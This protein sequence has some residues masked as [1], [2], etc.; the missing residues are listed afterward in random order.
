M[1]DT[2]RF[3]KI[4]DAEQQAKGVVSLAIRPNMPSQYGQGGLTGKQLQERFDRL[5]RYI[6]EKYNILVDGLASHD[7]LDYFKLPEGY[8]LDTLHD[9]IEKISDSHGD[10]IVRSPYINGEEKLS[11]IL[12]KLR[13][14][15]DEIEVSG[16]GGGILD[17]DQLP[18]ENIMFTVFYRTPEGVYWYDNG[19]HKVAN[20]IDLENLEGRIDTVE[21]IAKG[22][23]QAR[24]YGDY[25]TMIEALNALPN[26][27]YNV[28]Q[29]IMI[30][31]LNVP[32]LWVSAI[33]E[34]HVEY[35]YVDDTTLANEIFT[36]GSVQVGYYVLSALETQKVDLTDYVKNTDYAGSIADNAYGVMAIT[37]AS[38]C[39]LNW[40]YS[41]N[42]K[43]L[44]IQ[45]PD[46]VAV[47]RRNGTYP[48]VIGDLDTY[49]KTGITGLKQKQI[50]G[51]WTDSYGN[52]IALTDEEKASALAWLGA[53]GETDYATSEKAG[54]MYFKGT[55]AKILGDG[56]LYINYVT[57][58]DFKSGSGNNFLRVSNAKLVAK[59]GITK[60]SADSNLALTD[61]E[62]ASAQDWLGIS[63]SSKLYKH[64]V[65]VHYEQD[66]GFFDGTL[67]KY[68]RDSAP[69]TSI[70]KNELLYEVNVI[71]LADYDE[72]YYGLAGRFD[73]G[74]ANTVVF[75][76]FNETRQT[77]EQVLLDVRFFT[78]TDTV[79][80][81]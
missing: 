79:T 46:S 65:N 14:E 53:V 13:R 48:L 70:T 30:V 80:E 34:E 55:G 49:I 44:K 11:T 58:N 59:Y 15:I 51:V 5:A 69:I 42:K 35:A 17:V 20:E 67:I 21:S 31:T 73:N 45:S 23:G 56:E 81:V 75:L 8:S 12:N 78:I 50:D 66:N 47:K 32:D 43:F 61:E 68:N 33:A 62:K 40:G 7:V 57:E 77:I 10:L 76:G 54:L 19:W 16:G 74:E 36:N 18:T 60:A 6:I 64:L 24:S 3:E 2:K 63:G 27:V 22:A 25:A 1:S 72:E 38:S 41:A 71:G 26:D 52:Q 4:S 9:L 28:G 37:Y 29:N 39:G